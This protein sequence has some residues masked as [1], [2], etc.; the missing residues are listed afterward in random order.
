MSIIE[1]QYY[2][3]RAESIDQV[4]KIDLHGNY[5]IPTQLYKYISE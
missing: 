2:L 3:L 4:I 5:E 1:R